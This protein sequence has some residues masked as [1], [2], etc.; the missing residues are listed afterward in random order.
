MVR[1]T[2]RRIL[3]IAVL[4]TSLSGC[5]A[6]TALFR[7]A[8]DSPS[9][10]G[11]AASRVTDPN[12]LASTAAATADSSAI[13]IPRLTERAG[14]GAH[15][16]SRDAADLWDRIRGGLQYAGSDRPEVEKE[17]RFYARYDQF[18]AR[19]TQRARPFLHH[20]VEE[21]ERRQM[22]LDLALLPI[23]ESAFQPTARSRSGAVGIWQ[24]IPATGRRF[25]LVTIVVVQMFPQ[26]LAV[27]A[28]FLLMSTIGDWFPALGLD[29]HA[30][31]IAVYMGGALGV[32]TYLM[33]GFFNT[34][35]VSI[36]EAAKID[37]AGHARI[38]FTIVLR[39]VAP[40]LAVVA[41]L[42]FIATVNDY[43]IASVMLIEPTN[44]TL[45]VGM[46]GMVSNPRYA[47]WSGFSAGAVM[48]ALP[49]M[50]VFLALQKYI[51]GGLTA[52]AV[53]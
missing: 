41:L 17:V 22:P 4:G 9:T 12:S 52:G 30:G 24:F 3:T 37:G 25:G 7:G 47:D 35:P 5:S 1:G 50:I 15:D 11:T 53:K 39:L 34:I 8:G 32:N 45:A 51:V 14:A 10:A 2:F 49:V 43:V 21:L 44:Q 26:L 31:L 40:I 29:T 20:I 36:D 28:I 19:T 18:I 38:F 33:Y 23:V 13:R 46:Y 42:S 27:V 16:V 6:I 48:A